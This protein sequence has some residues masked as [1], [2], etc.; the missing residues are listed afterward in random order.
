METNPKNPQESSS[1]TP[2]PY[3]VRISDNGSR[4]F[5]TD[6]GITYQLAFAPQASSFPD[7]PFAENLVTLAIVPLR[8]YTRRTLQKEKS[9][10]RIELTIMG[11][12]QHFFEVNPLLVIAYTCDTGN[13]LEEARF[14]L[15]KR[16]YRKYLEQEGIIHMPYESPSTRV[17]AGVLYR[18]DNPYK[19]AIEEEFNA[20][21]RGK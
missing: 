13:E 17:Y 7:S 1:S 6:R 3:P 18:Q 21:L 4:L 11:L 14:I 9:D 10:S 8:G 15:F 12:L 2:Y 5:D 16:W 19:D 20:Q